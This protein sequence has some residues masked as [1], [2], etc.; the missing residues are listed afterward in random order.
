V[1]ASAIAA[2]RLLAADG[3]AKSGDEPYVFTLNGKPF[4]PE[5]YSLAGTPETPREG[6][7]I[8]VKELLPGDTSYDPRDSEF[9]ESASE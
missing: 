6:D 8:K 1:V 4:T 5:V 2:G 3:A 7:V 9:G